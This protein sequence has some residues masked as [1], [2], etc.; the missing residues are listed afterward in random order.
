M[1]HVARTEKKRNACRPLVEKS[2][3]TRQIARARRR[4]K[5][6][7]KMVLKEIRW[8]GCDRDKWRIFVT[9]LTVTEIHGGLL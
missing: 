8:R 9:T 2:E 3:G 7:I 6:N 4:W 5:N 1:G